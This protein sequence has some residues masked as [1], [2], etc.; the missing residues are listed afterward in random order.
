VSKEK[1]T[2]LLDSLISSDSFIPA[3]EDEKSFVLALAS[4]INSLI[5]SDFEKL[6]QILYRLDINENNLKQTLKEQL[7]DEAGLIIARMIIERQ[8]QKSR[9]RQ[10]FRS[11]DAIAD[12]EKW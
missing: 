9:T 7:N 2:K 3:G 4:E 11:D 12:D 5:L 10:Q 6:V 8:V 1:D